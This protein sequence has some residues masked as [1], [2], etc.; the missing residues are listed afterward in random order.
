MMTLRPDPGGRKLDRCG[1]LDPGLAQ[2]LIGRQFLDVAKQEP[3]RVH[4]PEEHLDHVAT[5]PECCLIEPGQPPIQSSVPNVV[6]YYSPPV[7]QP[8]Q[9]SDDVADSNLAATSR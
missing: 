6:L 9:G 3:H 7:K 8:T 5:V 2:L 4:R 1:W